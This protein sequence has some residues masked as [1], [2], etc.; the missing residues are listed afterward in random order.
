MIHVGLS[1]IW[2]VNPLFKKIDHPLPLPLFEKSYFSCYICIWT[3]IA[4]YNLTGLTFKQHGFE[5][6]RYK[7]ILTPHLFFSIKGYYS[8]IFYAEY[9]MQNGG[10]D[11]SQAG[12]KIARRNTSNLRYANDTTIMAES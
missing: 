12:I 5:L 4:A 11:E 6:P 1:N 7:Y 3:N 9:T 2:S 8:T 10:L